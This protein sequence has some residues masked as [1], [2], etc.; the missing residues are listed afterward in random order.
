ME[1]IQLFSFIVVTSLLV[2]S[3]GP[4]GLLIAKTVPTSGKKAGFLNIAGFVAAFYLHGCVSIFGLAALLY[5]SATA[6]MLLKIV[7]AIYLT[8]IGLKSLWAAYKPK[9]SS[10]EDATTLSSPLTTLTKRSA[11]WEGFLTNALN[12]KV[13]MFYLAAFPQFI[14]NHQQAIVYALLLVTVH[15]LIALLWFSS[16]VVLMSKLSS[17]VNK[18]LFQGLLKSITGLVFIGF[19]A[20]L[21]MLNN[22]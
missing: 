2:I 1:Y 11:F 8:W 10:S 22:K 20:K 3:P 9:P 21:L 18:G 5:Q 16:L 6:F 7:G 19:G 14:P 13:S 17:M 15:A 4:N 12:P